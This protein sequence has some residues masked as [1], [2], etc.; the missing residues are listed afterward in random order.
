MRLASIV[1]T[2]AVLVVLIVPGCGSGLLL[3]VYSVEG[4]PSTPSVAGK[5]VDLSGLKPLGAVRLFFYPYVSDSTIHQVPERE[6]LTNGAGCAEYF[7][8][9]SPF[10]SKMGALVAMKPGYFVDTIFFHYRPE[11]TLSVLVSMHRR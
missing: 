7:E 4:D 3:R 2:L 5:S 11:D 1:R 10:S 6:L 9:A 8:N